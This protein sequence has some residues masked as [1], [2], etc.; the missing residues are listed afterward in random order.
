MIAETT[1]NADL[2][3]CEDLK[4]AIYTGGA[5]TFDAVMENYITILT[6]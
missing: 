2:F 1:D 6:G 3:A 5:Q 4:I